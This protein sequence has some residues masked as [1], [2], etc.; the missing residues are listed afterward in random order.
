[1]TKQIDTLIHDEALL[2]KFSGQALEIAQQ[3]TSDIHVE[4]VEKLYKQ[5]L[6]M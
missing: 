2:K 3:F 5:V 1:M 4:K 6:G